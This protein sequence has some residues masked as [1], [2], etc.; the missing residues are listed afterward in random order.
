MKSVYILALLAYAAFSVTDASV[1]AA[2][3]HLSIFQVAFMVNVFA[4]LSVLATRHP[5]ER[6]RDFWRT[7]HPLAVHGRAICGVVASVSGVYAFTTIPLAQAYALVFLAPLFVT[8]M[9]ALVLKEYVGLWRWFAVAIGF[10]GVLLVVKPGHQP[11]EAGHLAAIFTGLGTGT[12]VIILRRIGGKVKTTSVLGTLILYLLVLNAVAM[13]IHGASIPTFRECA[14]LA[15]AGMSYGL[16]QWALVSATRYG[17]ATQIAPMHYSQLAWAV[18]FGALIFNEF[19][20]AIALAGIVVIASAG[21]LTVLRERL[22]GMRSSVAL[23]ATVGIPD[24]DPVADP[25][26]EPA[27]DPAETVKRAEDFH[28]R[29]FPK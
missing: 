9:S 23:A 29:P 8:I 7:P 17:N 4:A 13:L 1:K 19:P 11:F 22:R 3:S 15:L 2:G 27:K 21:L 12:A 14:L 16:G 26:E 28:R 18:L 24:G 6:W 5:G 20:D 10:V 25:L